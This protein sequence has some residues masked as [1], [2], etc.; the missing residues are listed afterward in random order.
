L[1]PEGWEITRDGREYLST[2]GIV[3]VAHGVAQVATDLRAFLDKIT[4]AEVRSF[5]EE[6][7]CCYESQLFI[8][9][10]VMSWLAAIAVLHRHVLA[11]HLPAFN[12]EASRV[13]ARWRAAVTTDDLGRM[14]ESDF[15]DRLAAISVLG[16]NTKAQLVQALNL[17]N[18]CGH[19]SS[20]KVSANT[21]AA[22]IEMLLLNVFDKFSV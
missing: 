22:H 19:P 14:K 9:A 6:A 7:I 21:A 20:H 12:A 8:S 11:A 17:R 18:T 13:D 15:L 4:N 5:V 3:Q 1:L 2:L 16:R 10:I